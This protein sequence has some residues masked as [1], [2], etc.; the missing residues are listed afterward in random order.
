VPAA[1][2]AVIVANASKERAPI[3]L[4]RNLAGCWERRAG[5]AASL[6]HLEGSTTNTWP[7]SSWGKE[8]LHVGANKTHQQKGDRARMLGES[9]EFKRLR[10]AVEKAAGNRERA[11]RNVCRLY[12]VNRFDALPGAIG[13]RCWRCST[14]AYRLS[15]HGAAG[16]RASFVTSGG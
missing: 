12:T 7:P 1:G 8:A 15:D 3:I 13:P 11:I 14:R 16:V 10:R 5:L 4:S 6:T 2:W 9:D